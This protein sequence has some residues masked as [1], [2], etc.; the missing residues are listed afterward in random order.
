MNQLKLNLG[1]FNQCVDYSSERKNRPVDPN[2]KVFYCK[3]LEAD[4]E[5]PVSNVGEQLEGDRL[6]NRQRREL[7]S[8]GLFE[9]PTFVMAKNN[10]YGIDHLLSLVELDF[11][12]RIKE[13]IEESGGHAKFEDIVIQVKS[14]QIFDEQSEAIK[15]GRYALVNFGIAVV[16]PA[17]ESVVS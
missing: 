12:A 9:I 11:L 16:V 4:A 5:R 15:N 14:A 17:V 13:T 6:N 7:L 2:A 10:Q 1:Q 8:N 3:S